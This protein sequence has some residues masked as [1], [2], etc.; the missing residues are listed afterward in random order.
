V[1][2]STDDRPPTEAPIYWFAKLEFALE[3]G[4]LQAA[5][6]A[7]RELAHLGVRVQYGRPDRKAVAGAAR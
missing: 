2:P 7:Q 6:E 5:A 4:D 1:P 3:D